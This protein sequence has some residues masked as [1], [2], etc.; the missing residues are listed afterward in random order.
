MDSV[1]LNSSAI[2]RGVI[3]SSSQSELIPERFADNEII[4]R[5][6]SCFGDDEHNY[7]SQALAT[8]E[9]YVELFGEE[10]RKFQELVDQGKYHGPFDLMKKLP[11]GSPLFDLDSE[12]DK[13]VGLKRELFLDPERRKV[14]FQSSGEFKE[15]WTKFLE[16]LS[17]KHNSQFLFANNK[18]TNEITGEEWDLNKHDPMDVASLSVQEDLILLEKKPGDSPVIRDISVCFPSRWSPMT[19]PGRRVIDVHQIVPKFIAAGLGNSINDILNNLHDAGIRFTRLVHP[20]SQLN[21]S[22]ELGLKEIPD[23][24]NYDKNNIEDLF[25]RVEKQRFFSG[26]YITGDPKFK[27]LLMMSI[28]TYVLPLSALKASPAFA[29]GLLRLHQRFVDEKPVDDKR[30]YDVFRKYR[31]GTESFLLPLLD[32]LKEISDKQPDKRA[33]ETIY[34][35]RDL[36]LR[37]IVLGV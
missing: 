8:M 7:F 1:S 36:Y 2:G 25:V 34:V 10:P 31:G 14:A 28:K 15:F 27:D 19:A 37:P 22:A 24:V 23:G 11:K 26:D 17:K 29:K 3:M 35:P 5:V 13:Y 21:Q 4:Q 20:F 16:S 6:R 12:Y 18:F 33:L 32:Y 9:L 30:P